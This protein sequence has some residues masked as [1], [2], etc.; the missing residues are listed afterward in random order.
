MC[1]AH[2]YTAANLR[3]AMHALPH[4]NAIAERA[5]ALDVDMGLAHSSLPSTLEQELATNPFLLA[6]HDGV[7]ALGAMRRAKD[8]FPS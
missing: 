6:L 1:C 2:E 3:F 4:V 5:R 7:E 8:A